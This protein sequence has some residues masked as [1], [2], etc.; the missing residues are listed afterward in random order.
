MINH[1]FPE[2]LVNNLPNSVQWTASHMHCRLVT[3]F[4]TPKLFK[5]RK[6][7]NIAKSVSKKILR[8]LPSK[9]VSF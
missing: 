4:S 2:K 5:K 9:Y 3:I 8:I 1:T 7:L 6:Q